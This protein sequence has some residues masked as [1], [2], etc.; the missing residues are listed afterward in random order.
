M[1]QE[2]FTLPEAA[3]FLSLPDHAVL[4]LAATELLPISFDFDGELSGVEI[5]HHDGR[6]ENAGVSI[7]EFRGVLRALSPSISRESATVTL[8]EILSE[9]GGRRINRPNGIVLPTEHPYGGRI[10]GAR[11]T[12]VVDFVEVPSEAWFFD[13]RDLRLLDASTAPKVGAGGTVP[14]ENPKRQKLR[15]MLERI[16]GLDP[17][18]MP[19]QKIDIHALARAYDKDFQVSPAT[20]SDYL[21]KPAS[22]PKLCA[23]GQGTKRDPDYYRSICD[24]VGVTTAAYN[25]ALRD[26]E[27]QTASGKAKKGDGGN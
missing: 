11:V 1:K 24:Q 12:G 26:L 22:L 13:V 14:A 19:G 5:I 3:T 20:F 25:L 7:T 17:G 8:V 18:N 15:A 23:F 27:K 21:D 6:Q 4:R 9:D 10:L 2:F 16:K